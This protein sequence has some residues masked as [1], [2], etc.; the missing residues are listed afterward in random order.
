MLSS[1]IFFVLCCL[2]FSSPL[3]IRIHPPDVIG[4]YAP[5]SVI[6]MIGSGGGGA[7]VAGAPAGGG[8]G[9]ISMAEVAKHNSKSDCWVAWFKFWVLAFVGSCCAVGTNFGKRL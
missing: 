2:N 7:V 8:G 6:G 4:K 3:C 9:G 5:D 1:F